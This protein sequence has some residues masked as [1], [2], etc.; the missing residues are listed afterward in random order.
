MTDAS[1][2][3]RVIR[4]MPVA[5]SHTHHLA[6][7]WHTGLDLNRLLQSSY[8]N[9]L[10]IPPA[11]PDAHPADLIDQIG[12]NTYFSW[13]SKSV[14]E[15]YGLG[16]I[17]PHNWDA[18]SDAMRRAH[19]DPEHQVRVLT[20][21]MRLLYG[22]LD[23]NPRPGWDLGRPELFRPAYRIDHWCMGCRPGEFGDWPVDPWKT[24]GFD[25]ATLDEYLDAMDATLV[26]AKRNG[27]VAIKNPLAY[28]R[29]LAFDRPDREAAR[30]AFRANGDVAYTDLLAFGDVVFE[31]ALEIAEREG[32]P[33]QV[34]L[35]LAR[36]ATS[37]PMFFERTI[38]RRPNVTFDLFHCGY[39]WVDEIGGLLHNYA[40]VVADLCWLPYIS[41]YAAER[42][43]NEYLD[44]ARSSDRILWG[45]DALP[46]E[47]AYGA[48]LAWE[49][50]VSR[51]LTRRVNDGLCT[52]HQAERLAEKLM[53]ANV[54]RLYG[55][56]G[57]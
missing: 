14:A 28:N 36:L 51:T 46:S 29:T 19:E 40:N 42:A 27:L 54:E 37:G 5:S 1:G 43:L 38:A 55:R 53:H 21:R 22:V 24:E 11:K 33:V 52:T 18:I 49:H 16:E 15:I 10:G 2:L 50:V 45:D 13:L 48:L 9:W 41:T 31:R 56:G 47:D 57:L 17:A 7:G 44:V 39:P 23:C 12:T 30:R 32:L 34:H 8:V 6:D 20:E 35:G 25:P 26:E 3:A 4:G